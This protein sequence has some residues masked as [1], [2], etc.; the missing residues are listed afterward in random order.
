[1]SYALAEGAAKERAGNTGVLPAQE[2]RV[3]LAFSTRIMALV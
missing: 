3:H 2:I 1:M